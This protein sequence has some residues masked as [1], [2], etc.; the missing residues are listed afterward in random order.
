VLRRSE[1]AQYIEVGRGSAKKRKVVPT[2]W[3]DKDG[4]TIIWNPGKRLKGWLKDVVATLKSS[5]RNKVQYGMICKSLPNPGY[6][7]IAKITDI[8]PSKDWHSFPHAEDYDLGGLPEPNV[9]VVVLDRGSIFALHY[10]INKPVIVQAEIFCFARGI[11]AENVKDWMETIGSYKG[12]GDLHN[13][14]EGYGCFKVKKFE[15]KEEKTIHF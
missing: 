14:S 11:N 13:S 6:V 5:W 9:E 15:V 2:D 8:E 12:L 3:L 10:V 4:E 7:P 1:A